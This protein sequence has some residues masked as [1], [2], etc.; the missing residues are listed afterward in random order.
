MYFKKLFIIHI[1][2]WLLRDKLVP[3]R[4]TRTEN[5]NTR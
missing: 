5:S 4:S 3:S 1:S 2:Q